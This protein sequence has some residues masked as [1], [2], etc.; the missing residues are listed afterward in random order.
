[1]KEKAITVTEAARDFAG[2]VNR[3]HHERMIFVLLENGVPIARLVP[4]TE[5]RLT[6]GE[7][8]DA[9]RD[10]PLSAEEAES[11]REEIRRARETL[12][13]PKERWRSSSM[14]MSLSAPKRSDSISNHG[15]ASTRLRGSHVATFNRQHFENV[16]GLTV[17]E[18]I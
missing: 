8:A 6:A 17:I 9:L 16:P 1:M 4:E 15:F 5:K 2:C 3:A 11:W 12:V 14:P 13:P 10:N 18:P 7:L